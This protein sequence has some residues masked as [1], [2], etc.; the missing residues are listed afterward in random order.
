ME[1]SKKLNNFT[2]NGFSTGG[3]STIKHL[4][5]CTNSS[6][7]RNYF[8]FSGCMQVM[9]VYRNVKSGKGLLNMVADQPSISK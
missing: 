7:R 3:F 9:K 6:V 1:I 2:E 5:I 8:F 4:D